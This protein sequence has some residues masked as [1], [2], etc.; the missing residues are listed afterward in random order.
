MAQTYIIASI[1]PK[2]MSGQP[3][4]D[5]DLWSSSN[6]KDIIAEV[7]NVRSAVL[8][9]ESFLDLSQ[10][11]DHLQS[12]RNLVHYLA[13]RRFDLRST[14]EKL[15]SLG[16]SSLGRSEGHVLYNLNVVLAVLH[17]LAGLAP[18]RLDVRAVT[19]SEGRSILERNATRLLGPRRRGRAVRIMVTM[20]KQASTDYILV[21]DLLASGMDCMRINCAHDTESDWRGMVSNLRRAEKETGRSCRI[22]M[23]IAGPKPRT[24]PLKPG[25]QVVKVKP[26]RN[27]LGAIV[28]PARVWLTPGE[29]REDPTSRADAI[30]PLPGRFIAGLVPGAVLRLRDSRGSRREFRVEA[31]AGKSAWASSDNTA[32]VTTGTSISDRGRK[33]LVGDLPHLPQSI[34]L[35]VGDTLTVSGARIPGRDALCDSTGRVRSPALI[36]CTLP[37]VL[38]RVEK[39]QPI[40]FDDGK[41]GGVV[42]SASRTELTVRIASAAVDGS[43]LREDKGINLPKTDLGQKPMTDKDFRDLAFIAKNADLVGYS[44]IRTASDV[45]SLRKALLER[46]GAGVGLILKIETQKAF[47][48]LPNILLAA[49]QTPLAGVMIARG[50]LAVECGYERLSEVQEEILWLCEAAHMPTIWATEVLERLTKSG[51]PS[52][53][54]VTDAAMGE[55]SECVMLNKGPYMVEAVRALD[56]ILERMQAH[57]SKKSDLLR[58]LNIAEGFFD[59]PGIKSTRQ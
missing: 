21:R 57:H 6:V 36:S 35:K 26:R 49:L 13:L 39:G 58:H 18:P 22:L 30:L 8:K 56:N 45:G 14:Q 20:P 15:A 38:A 11:S 51:T 1:V 59:G 2:Q 47:E 43:R 25:P 55:R 34:N 5:Y 12:A 41:I 46:G 52:R 53:A 28:A 16:V 42:T 10:F 37:D 17:R 31:R 44:F 32:Y 19:P 9:Q 4:V 3:G 7:D 29:S 27:Q 48:Q 50:D 54:E 23:D 40:W 24:G 33:G